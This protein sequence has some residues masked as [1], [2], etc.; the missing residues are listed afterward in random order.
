MQRRYARRSFLVVALGNL[1][2][3]GCARTPPTQEEDVELAVRK[4]E[5]RE[6]W[7]LFSLFA[8]QQ[9]RAPMALTDLRGS[10]IA[11]PNGYAALES[12]RVQVIWGANPAATA[13]T[14]ILA[15]ESAVPEQGGLVV[16]R[17]GSVKNLSAQEFQA[18]HRAP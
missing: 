10:A 5:L 1:I 8:T 14:A 13:G 2:W 12:G 15:Y 9:N 6:I 7:E 17:D 3:I 18:F 4:E 16:L 11:F